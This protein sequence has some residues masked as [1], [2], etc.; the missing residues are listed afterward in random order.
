MEE[1]ESKD[2]AMSC[3][4]VFFGAIQDFFGGQLGT[5]LLVGMPGSCRMVLWQIVTMMLLGLIMIL[6][7]R[8]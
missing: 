3:I 1:A 8:R 7:W 5:G 4:H 2:G 6:Y